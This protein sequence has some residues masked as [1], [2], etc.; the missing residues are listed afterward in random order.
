MSDDDSGMNASEVV[1]SD[2]DAD[3]IEAFPLTTPHRKT[4]AALVAADKEGASP[5]KAFFLSLA[6]LI[7]FRIR[8]SAH[9]LSR[10]CMGHRNR[11]NRGC[12][13]AEPP[14]KGHPLAAQHWRA[15]RRCEH[16]RLGEEH[17][18]AR[19]PR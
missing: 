15:K 12:W 10:E 3:T 5:L 17:L 9:N 6:D 8:E 7:I 18:G 16:G 11:R 2:T 13:R 4:N 1:V 19:Q 14:V